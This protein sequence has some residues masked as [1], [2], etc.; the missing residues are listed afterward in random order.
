MAEA[1]L[2]RTATYYCN[3]DSLAKGQWLPIG[4]EGAFTRV[5]AH[6]EHHGFP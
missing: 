4:E 6:A 2:G 5:E 1:R 3:I